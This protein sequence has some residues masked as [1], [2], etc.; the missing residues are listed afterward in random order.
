MSGFRRWS[1]SQTCSYSCNLF[2]TSQNCRPIVKWAS[3]Q[4]KRSCHLSFI[5]FLKLTFHHILN[6][7]FISYYPLFVSVCPFFEFRH[8]WSLTGIKE[9][10][11]SG[12]CPKLA[13][14]K[15]KKFILWIDIM[16]SVGFRSLSHNIIKHSFQIVDEFPQTNLQVCTRTNYT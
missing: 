8:I 12:S 5:S 1:S 10:T 4:I 15:L 11:L 2:D 6:P 3:W 13:K 9:E 14:W 16:V 7:F